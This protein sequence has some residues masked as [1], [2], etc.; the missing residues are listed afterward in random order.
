MSG[1]H[2][3]AACRAAGTTELAELARSPYLVLI[4]ASG[5]AGLIEF[6]G[7]AAERGLVRDALLAQS[8]AQRRAMW[9]LRED[10]AVDR[11]R[12]G[13]LWYDVSVPLGALPGYLEACAARLA[14]HDREL[15]LFVIGHLADG[16]VHVTVNAPRP[17]T[18]RYEEVAGLV[19]DGLGALGGSYSAEHG[20]GLEKRATLARLASPARLALMRTLKAALDPRGILNPG[21]VLPE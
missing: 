5:E 18:A 13:G 15:A 21:K 12:P 7:A 17:I 14:A 20:I 9:H 8:E 10:W 2:A 1:S 19:T 16:N 4:E 6:L 3:E 11:E